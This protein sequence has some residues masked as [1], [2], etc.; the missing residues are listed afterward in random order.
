MQTVRSDGKCMKIA[1]AIFD[2]D[3]VLLDS[4]FLWDTLGETYLR[5]RGIQPREDINEVLRPMSLLQAA[6]YF[7]ADYGINDSV[8]EIMDGINRLVEHYYV[9]LVKPKPGVIHYLD[10]LKNNHVKMCITTA[11]DRFMV[12]AAMKRNRMEQYFEKIFTCTEVGHGKDEPDIYL[13]ALS[14]LG[15]SK[16]ETMVF[17]DALYAIRTAKNADFPVV[18]VYDESARSQQAKIIKL[19]D[20]YITTFEEMELK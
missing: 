13:Q 2:L 19:A 12:D 5:S 3:G 1:G 11:T 10:K 6:T 17:E 8:Q 7:H 18:A 4:M 14:Y 20:A 15:T 9:D 16:N